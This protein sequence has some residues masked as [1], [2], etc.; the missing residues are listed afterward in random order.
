MPNIAS[1]IKSHNIKVATNNKDTPQESPK[2]CNC[3]KKEKPNCPLQ[4]NC[5]AASIIY[6]AEVKVTNEPT[7]TKAYIGLTELTFKKRYYNHVQS[8]KKEAKKHSTE[9]SR[10][11]WQLKKKKKPHTIS[12]SIVTK[13]RPYSNGSKRCDLCLTEKLAIINADKQNLLNKRS[14]LISKCRHENKFYLTKC[15]GNIT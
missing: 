15:A 11:V 14:E 2:T 5:L 4:G 7:N 6:K 12:W 10:Y 13:A 8:F 9:L 3:P 1:V